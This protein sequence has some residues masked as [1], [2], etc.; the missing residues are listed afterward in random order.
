MKKIGMIALA[1]LTVFLSLALSVNAAGSLSISASSAALKVGESITFTVSL[2]GAPSATS[3]SVQMSYE[4]K[5]FSFVSGEFLKS[6]ASLSHYDSSNHVG[7]ILFPDETDFNGKYFKIVL[8]V[9]NSSAAQTVKAEVQLRKGSD[10]LGEYSASVK[11]NAGAAADHIWS[12]WKIEKKASCE[13]AGTETR[14]CSDCGKTETREIKALGH[15]WSR[16]EQIQAADCETAGKETR[17][18]SRCGKT[19]TAEIPALGHDWSAW[20]TGKAAD[21]E[22]KGEEGRSC[23]RCGKTESRETAPLGH[24]FENPVVLREPSLSHPGLTEGTC[25]RCG[26]TAQQ[27]IP[28]RGVDEATGV[29]LQFDDGVFPEGVSFSVTKAEKDSEAYQAAE[30]ALKEIAR[31]FVLFDIAARKGEIAVQPAGE[32]FVSFP[33][34]EGFE[35]AALYAVSDTGEAEEIEA[36]L[37]ADGKMI[38]AEVTALSRYAVVKTDSPATDPASDPAPPAPSVPVSSEILP[39]SPNEEEEPK[40]SGVLVPILVIAA[41][42]LAS[43]GGAAFFFLKKKK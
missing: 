6:G 18:C 14:T 23:S 36:A 5:A 2:S 39:A 3:A 1:A 12:E 25:S 30:S 31:D 19:E 41:V 40:E 21:C 9:K 20:K 42:A 8:K 24:E 15:D 17:S 27:V 7:A 32:V 43:A 35:G 26:K 13:A 16:K 4:D 10:T 37:S 22:K 11:L 28:C 38:T 33:I 34:P 29:A